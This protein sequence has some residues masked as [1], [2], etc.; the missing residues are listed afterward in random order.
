MTTPFIRNH[1]YN[2]IKKQATLLQHT[3]Q[4]VADHKIVDTVRYSAFT[5]I[6]EAFQSAEEQQLRLLERITTLDKTE[7]FSQFLLS[8][9]PYLI[10]FEQVTDKQLKKLYPKSK[11]LKLPN[12]EGLDLRHTTYL[13]WTDIG[14]NRMYLIYQLDGRLVGIEGK[15]TQAKKKGT[16]FLCNRQEE[17]ALFTAETKTKPANATPDYYKAIGN[18]M[19]VNSHTCNQNITDKTALEMFIRS[20]IG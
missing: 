7:E 12:M 4:T 10:E 6:T 15:F 5:K 8:L 16:C 19:C 18:Y 2:L 14:T 1:Q 20:I 11:K 9:E 13:G 3:C 17:V